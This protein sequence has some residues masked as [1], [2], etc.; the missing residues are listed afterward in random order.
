MLGSTLTVTLDG[1]GGTARVCSLINQDANSSEYLNRGATDEVVVKV[2]HLRESAKVGELYPVERHNILFR[3]VVFATPTTTEKFR[4]VSFTIRNRPD[5]AAVD[6]V[7]LAE[8][9]SFWTV[10]ANANNEK[11]VAWEV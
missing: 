4:E 3:H 2:R 5:D 1:S 10:K 7:N 8:A 11:L 9:M 6:V